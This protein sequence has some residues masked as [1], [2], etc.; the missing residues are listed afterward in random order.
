MGND[1]QK[2]DHSCDGNQCL[3]DE[4]GGPGGHLRYDGLEQVTFTS[5]APFSLARYVF[6]SYAL[7]ICY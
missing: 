2:H 4:G 1:N 7:L 6:S 5:S 3:A